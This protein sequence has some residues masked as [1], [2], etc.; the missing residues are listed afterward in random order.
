VLRSE[1]AG[2]AGLLPFAVALTGTILA[3]TRAIDSLGFDAAARAFDAL[4]LLLILPVPFLF[5][6]AL[7]RRRQIRQSLAAT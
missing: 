2:Q 3:T 4:M 7:W 6:S 5:Y 1:I